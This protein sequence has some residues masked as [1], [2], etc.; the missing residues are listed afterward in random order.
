VRTRNTVITGLLS[1]LFLISFAS[2]TSV[3]V[4]RGSDFNRYYD[5]ATGKYILQVFNSPEYVL[6]NSK[7]VHVTQAKSLMGIWQIN[8]LKNDS[9]FPLQVLDLNF[10][11]IT[12]NI[13]SALTGTIPFQWCKDVCL[14]AKNCSANTITQCNNM[15]VSILSASRN[16]FQTFIVPISDATSF[17]NITWGTATTTIQIGNGGVFDDTTIAA[18]SPRNS[19]A[20]GSA[21][22]LGYGYMSTYKLYFAAKFNISAIP[23]GVTINDAS[24]SFT[25]VSNGLDV[26]ENQTIGAFHIYNSSGGYTI[27]GQDWIEG[28]A[29]NTPGCDIT[30]GANATGVMTWNVRPTTSS[31]MN[32]TAESTRLIGNKTYDPLGTVETWNV[33]N[34]VALEY[35]TNTLTNRVNVS[36][37]FS[38]VAKGGS[39]DTYDCFA[40]NSSEA[41]IGKP[42]LNVTYTEGGAQPN[43]TSQPVYDSFTYAELAVVSM[44]WGRIL[45][46]AGTYAELQLR[47]LTLTRVFYDY[48]TYAELLITS[49][50]HPR[51][52]YDSVTYS[53]LQ[54][55][56][57]IFPRVLYDSVT[58]AEDLV[59]NSIFGMMLYDYVTYAESVIKNSAFA[60]MLYD[61]T[62]YAESIIKQSVFGIVVYDYATYAENV[63]TSVVTSAKEYAVYL[64]DSAVYAESVLRGLALSINIYDAAAYA[65]NM[66]RGIA[67]T[68]NIYDSMA[69]AEN[70]VASVSAFVS[71][72]VEQA[73]S[74]IPPLN[75]PPVRIDFS[76]ISVIILGCI[77]V[78]GVNYMR[79]RKPDTQ[80]EE[81]LNEEFPDNEE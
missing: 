30:G 1:F 75:I 31:Q 49:A 3:L 57:S 15:T 64:Y 35:A 38:Y 54:T 25:L 21:T 60:R 34:M 18:W 4:E 32:L 14:D 66:V 63:V 51:T 53:E 27:D 55:K 68:I 59:K 74:Y 81:T 76:W 20:Y 39:P 33:T 47:N 46:D 7:W 44:N 13:S 22:T 58:Y 52:F 24:E 42:Y 16:K 2:A 77:C 11:H 71:G 5:S 37:Y 43:V 9:N 62:A 50:L 6:E 26:A 48:D 79:N 78:F 61:L 65:E 56:L 36:T 8:Y 70:L 41:V 69:Y 40:F 17:K 29:T 73:M 67:V 12:I 28:A 45:Y 80:D 23:V 19:Q 72:V 10:T